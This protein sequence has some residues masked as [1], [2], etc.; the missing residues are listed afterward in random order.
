MNNLLTAERKFRIEEIFILALPA[1]IEMGLNTMLNLADTLMIGRIIGKEGLSAAGF[2]NQI[3]FTFIYIFSSFNA[4]A[5]AM[6]A[7][8]YGEKNYR[9][10]NKIL[11]QNISLNLIIGIIIFIISVTMSRSILNIY[12]FSEQVLSLGTTYLK[13]VSFSLPFLFFSFAAAAGLRGSGNTK[14]PMYITGT[15]NLINIAGNYVLITGY[16]IFPEMGI[17]GAAL[18]TTISRGIATVLYLWFIFKSNNK[19]RLSISNMKLSK[20]IIQPL[21]RFS[22]AAGLEQFSMQLSFFINGIIITQL[23]TTSEAA[24]R[25]LINV[26]AISYM[27]AVGM[28]IATTTLVGKHLGEKN[29]EESLKTGFTAAIMGIIWG[30]FIGIIFFVI[31]VPIIKIFTTDAEVVATSIYTLHIAGINQAPLA[32]LIILCGALRGTGDTRG[33]MIITAIRLWLMFIPLSYYFTIVLA[34][35]I[36]GTWYAEFIC[37]IIFSIVAGRRFYKMKWAEIRMF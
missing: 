33:V 22:Y 26:E 13:T 17:A 12:D 10:L 36:V 18:S 31:P 7:R 1:I 25:I 32:F 23:Q 14:T 27:P 19:I 11:A 21:W 20:K 9:R 6:I 28:A 35:G 3:I 15:A 16:S 30:L 8:S 24:Y 37:F 29:P 2:A 5:T 34:K 4:G